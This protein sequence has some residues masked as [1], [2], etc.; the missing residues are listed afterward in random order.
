MVRNRLP[1]E[2]TRPLNQSRGFAGR[3]PDGHTLS[4]ALVGFISL[5]GKMRLSCRGSMISLA[6]AAIESFRDRGRAVVAEVFQVRLADGRKLKAMDRA[7][8]VRGFKGGKIPPGSVIV[9]AHGDTIEISEFCNAKATNKGVLIVANTN[10]GIITMPE[11]LEIKPF[12]AVTRRKES[13]ISAFLI[14]AII[15][16]SV[17]FGYLLPRLPIF[18]LERELASAAKMSTNDS[19]LTGPASTP[20]APPERLLQ[21]DPTEVGKDP[22]SEVPHVTEAEPIAPEQQFADAERCQ[23]L[24]D[25]ISERLGI[26]LGALGFSSQS[27]KTT[28]T[29]VGD[30]IFIQSGL[31]GP[32]FVAKVRR[33]AFDVESIT[34]T[35]PRRSVEMGGFGPSV[36][37]ETALYAQAV[38]RTMEE[39][40]DVR[41]TSSQ[42]ESHRE[43][44]ERW[45]HQQL[46]EQWEFEWTLRTRMFGNLLATLERTVSGNH[47]VHQLTEIVVRRVVDENERTEAAAINAELHSRV[48]ANLASCKTWPEIQHM[49]KGIVGF[50]VQPTK[51]PEILHQILA[52][53]SMV[54]VAERLSY[55]GEQ[56]FHGAGVDVLEW[57]E[58]GRV[59]AKITFE[60]G[61]VKVVAAE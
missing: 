11:V 24:A 55:H 25:Q 54:A 58:N 22:A 28:N 16:I 31:N 6:C 53:D 7:K 4:L 27:G 40:N 52:G 46:R 59:A 15:L 42:S 33:P 10:R 1:E 18:K 32:T 26:R 48:R 51:T 38:F 49:T 47:T 37:N 50:D 13:G 61:I 2:G 57:V 8:I 5:V 30:R 44:I 45:L 14:I 35:S 20:S 17:T 56:K 9:S 60:E 41:S 34:I 23:A 3:D 39:L 29:V 43:W 19:I 12:P 21:N 36:N